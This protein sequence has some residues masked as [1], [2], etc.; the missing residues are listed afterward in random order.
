[1]VQILTY[2]QIMNYKFRYSHPT[3]SDEGQ[4]PP[5]SDLRNYQ[6]TEF[7]RAIYSAVSFSSLVLLMDSTFSR[8]SHTR[9]AIYKLLEVSRLSYTYGIYGIPFD[10]YIH[11]SRHVLINPPDW[12]MKGQT[13]SQIYGTS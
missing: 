4:L 7:L 2:V 8:T 11:I 9:V 12:I 10:M 1:M 6:D 3:I 13:A 5:D